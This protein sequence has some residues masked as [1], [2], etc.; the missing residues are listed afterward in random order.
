[1]NINTSH[2]QL[3]KQDHQPSRTNRR[4]GMKRLIAITF[5]VFAGLVPTASAHDITAAKAWEL[6][7]HSSAVW[8]WKASANHAYC[9]YYT[10][11]RADHIYWEHNWLG[12]HHIRVIHWH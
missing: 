10:W 1:M 4:R 8:C 5:I 2:I 7:G 11:P 6:S 9:D 12:Q 3:K